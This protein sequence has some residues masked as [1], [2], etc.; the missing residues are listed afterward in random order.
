MISF[1][2]QWRVDPLTPTCSCF[3]TVCEGADRRAL[4]AAFLGALRGG[5]VSAMYRKFLYIVETT[6][7]WDQ[8]FLK[9]TRSYSIE[10]HEFVPHVGTHHA[11]VG[12]R[13]LGYCHGV[14]F[15]IRT[16]PNLIRLCDQWRNDLQKLME[17]FRD[18][19]LVHGDLREP[20]ILCDGENR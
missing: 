16:S 9:L 8:L 3:A 15:V 19:D 6:P 11:F 17:E 12:F 20:N 18:N 2:R 13:S 14:P 5:V 4:Y 10:L 7:D 1:L